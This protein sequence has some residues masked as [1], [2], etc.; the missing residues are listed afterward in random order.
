VY[1]TDR[2]LSGG[3]L[4]PKLRGLGLSGLMELRALR[5]S[6]HNDGNISVGE[7]SMMSSWS[8]RLGA[9]SVLASGSP[10]RPPVGRGQGSLR[11]ALRPRRSARDFG[12]RL[13]ARRLVAAFASWRPGW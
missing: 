1:P 9:I 11:P 3:S 13:P 8:L 4:S 10:V 2:I 7:P 5:W 12:K 6:A